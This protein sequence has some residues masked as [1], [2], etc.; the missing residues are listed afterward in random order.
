MSEF[1]GLIH[2]SYE[3][4]EEGFRAGGAS[5]HSMMTAHG[6]DNDCFI[7]ATNDKLQ[8]TRVADG[9]MAFMFESS[10][11]LCLTDWSL[12]DRLLDED[13]YKCWSGLQKHFD[14]QK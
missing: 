5:L 12:N 4:K 1:M 3:A 13:Y 2:G 7:K 11:Q 6:P 14:G 9:T 10:L 8:P